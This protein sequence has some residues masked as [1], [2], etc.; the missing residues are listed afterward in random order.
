[1]FKKFLSLIMLASISIGLFGCGEGTVPLSYEDEDIIGEYDD[2]TIKLVDINGDAEYEKFY[3]EHIKKVKNLCKELGL[4]ASVDENG[5]RVTE[6]VNEYEDSWI[7]ISMYIIDDR[8]S[9]SI[10]AMEGADKSVD[11]IFSEVVSI[12][13]SYFNYSFEEEKIRTSLDENNS[14]KFGRGD[15]EEDFGTFE[16]SDSIV[17]FSMNVAKLTGVT[18][19]ICEYSISKEEVDK[20]DIYNNGKLNKLMNDFNILSSDIRVDIIETDY[21]SDLS[22]YFSDLDIELIHNFSLYN[23]EFYYGNEFRIYVD[24]GKELKEIFSRDEVKIMFQDLYDT[25]GEYDEILAKMS[26]ISN[27]EEDDR[28]TFDVDNLGKT[29]VS[30]YRR[31]VDDGSSYF[32]ISVDYKSAVK[33]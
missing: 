25:T 27:L 20:R 32:Y 21:I 18:K 29:K 30:I 11:D 31:N 23:N 13:N 24:E 19:E 10:Y 22:L 12:V 15:Y 14:Y 9:L 33:E 28:V 17:Q 3:N 6:F 26:L 1:M 2:I 16:L 8:A 7:N 4:N 5:I